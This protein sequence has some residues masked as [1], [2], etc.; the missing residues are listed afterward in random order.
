VLTCMAFYEV[1]KWSKSL[2]ESL[3]QSHDQLESR[4][5]EY[6]HVA[7]RELRDEITTSCP[8]RTGGT[9]PWMAASDSV[10]MADDE[11]EEEE[12]EEDEQQ[13]EESE[14]VTEIS[15]MILKMMSGD[16][17]MPPPLVTLENPMVEEEVNAPSDE[18]EGEVMDIDQEPPAVLPDAGQDGP[19]PPGAGDADLPSSPPRRRRRRQE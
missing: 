1:R 19:H 3:Q 18:K 13:E 16:V 12:E 2:S 7:I 11:E 15:A 8:L 9:C 4:M 14:P 6:V 10:P 5:Q 17:R